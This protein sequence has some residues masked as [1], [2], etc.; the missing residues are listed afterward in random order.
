MRSQKGYDLSFLLFPYEVFD[1]F[2]NVK[3]EE[4]KKWQR[5]LIFSMKVQNEGTKTEGFRAFED[6]EKFFKLSFIVLYSKKQV[7]LKTK[8]GNP[9]RLIKLS[10]KK[11]AEQPLSILY[12]G[13]TVS[14]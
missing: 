1:V 4:D 13:H 7:F 10:P 11:R 8:L 3:Y 12:V 14:E 2:P 5:C 9:F 6:L